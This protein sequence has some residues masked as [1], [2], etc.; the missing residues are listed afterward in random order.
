MEGVGKALEAFDAVLSASSLTLLLSVLYSS[1][2]IASP[3]GLMGLDGSLAVHAALLA[4]APVSARRGGSRAVSTI[5]LLAYVTDSVLTTRGDGFL[6][7]T[8]PGDLLALGTS[9][10]RDELLAV[11]LASIFLFTMSRYVYAYLAIAERAG[12]SKTLAPG[13]NLARGLAYPATL[14]V[15]VLG[16]TYSLAYASGGA[17]LVSMPLEA[18]LATVITTVVLILA[19]VYVRAKRV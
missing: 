1:K 19:Y 10:S 4:L 11:G 17:S 3:L 8:I 16:V 18:Y 15:V 5:A 6:F 14:L 2:T 13:P 7:W 12:R 9:L